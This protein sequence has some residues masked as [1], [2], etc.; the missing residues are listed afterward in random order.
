MKRLSERRLAG[1][2]IKVA[3][4]PSFSS[5]RTSSSPKDVTM[6]LQMQAGQYPNGFYGPGFR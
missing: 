2:K 1:I 3:P 4:I 6:S 5:G